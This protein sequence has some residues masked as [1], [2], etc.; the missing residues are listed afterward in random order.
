MGKPVMLPLTKHQVE[1]LRLVMQDYIDV[2]TDS[3]I[4]RDAML[5]KLKLD[6]LRS[7]STASTKGNHD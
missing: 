6:G 4:R 1:F 2:T 7:T 5:V 3:N